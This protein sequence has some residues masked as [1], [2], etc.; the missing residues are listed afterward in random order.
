MA[1]CCIDAVVVD[2]LRSVPCTF[3]NDILCGYVTSELGRWSW[4]RE[5]GK[6]KNT[7]TG[8]DA[9]PSGN[10][11]GEFLSCYNAIQLQAVCPSDV[12]PVLILNI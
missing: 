4:T 6:D 10:A 2:H 8:P 12:R 11:L 3:E 1:Q 9:D 5:V 7:L